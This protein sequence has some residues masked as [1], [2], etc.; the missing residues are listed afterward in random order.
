MHP[1]VV[2]EKPGECPICGMD[3]VA[4]EKPEAGGEVSRAAA[5]EREVLYWYD[6]MKPEVHFDRPG[7]SPFMDMDLLP[8]YADEAKGRTIDLTPEAAQAAGVVIVRAEQKRLEQ[9]TRAAGT[10]EVAET[11]LARI[12]ARVPGRLDR[13]YLNFTGETVRKGDPIYAIYSPE[14]VTAQREYLLALDNLG[15][16]RAGGDAS[17]LASAESLLEAAR[18]RLR[19][20]GIGQGQ[21]S[22][23]ERAQQPDLTVVVHSPVS[24]TV[25]ERHALLGQ[26]VVEGQDL[27]LLADLRHVWLQARVYEHELAA[28]RLGQ[29]AV[30]TLNSAPGRE[31]RGR[32]RFIEPVVDPT[33]RTARVRIELPNPDGALRPGMFA[34]AE[35]EADLGQRLVVPRS[36]LL[37]TGTRQVVYVREGEGSFVGREVRVGARAGEA[38]EILEGLE[39]GEEVVA[40][41]SFLIDSQSQ[42]QTGAS[43]QWGGASEVKDEKTPPPGQH[44]QHGGPGR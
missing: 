37:D 7:K 27:Y 24:G 16:A 34:N 18:G 44:G 20:W 30:V 5:T 17:Y 39:P 8:K 1:H 25:L 42:L 12:A 21:I 23:L 36:A 3:L 2:S 13:L 4:R 14:L 43:V 38:V 33:T 19:L 15:K 6:P 41:A 9:T 10:I 26:Y 32:V 40:K 29:E 35:L 28:L 22:R 11:A 31:Y